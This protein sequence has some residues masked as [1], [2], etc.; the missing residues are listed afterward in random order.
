M[1][2]IEREAFETGDQ[3]RARNRDPKNIGIGRTQIA[4]TDQFGTVIP[5]NARVRLV[6]A[7][8]GRYKVIHNETRID[9][10]PEG[11]L[12]FRV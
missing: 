2:N 6:Y 3:I 9:R 12:F 7:R 4:L 11:S 1:S 8:S 10:V 5:R